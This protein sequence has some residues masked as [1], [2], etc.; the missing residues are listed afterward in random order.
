M[1]SRLLPN[2]ILLG[3]PGSGKG[4]Q[5]KNLVGEFSY[6]HVSTG[7]LLRAEIKKGSDLGKKLKS[8]IDAGKLV[9]DNTVLEL[10]KANCDLEN[11]AYIFDGFPRN[12]EQ[13]Q[14]LDS[15]LIKSQKSLAVYFEMDQE[16][17]VKRIVN[18]RVAPKSGQIYNLISRPPRIA[19]KCDESGEDLVHRTDDKEEVVRERLKVFNENNTSLLD[20]YSKDKRLVKINADQDLSQVWSQL[21]NVIT[22]T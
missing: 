7:D 10:L 8:I 12:R 16:E 19:G 20:F 22:R 4:T 17:L 14:M 2:L 18:R 3:A 15:E 5:G 11:G 13:A 1:K 6:N 9:D 21:K